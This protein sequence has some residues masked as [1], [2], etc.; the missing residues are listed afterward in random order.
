MWSP[1]DLEEKMRLDHEKVTDNE[2]E[3]EDHFPASQRLLLHE[4]GDYWGEDDAGVDEDGECSE[5]K[6]AH[7]QSRAQHHDG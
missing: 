3:N 7:R 5:R 1:P 2:D 4:N 6:T